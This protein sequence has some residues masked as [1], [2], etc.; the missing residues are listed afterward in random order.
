[1]KKIL[2]YSLAAFCVLAVGAVAHSSASLQK[3][4]ID[5]LKSYGWEVSEKPIEKSDFTLPEQLDSVYENYNELQLEAGLNLI[6]H[7]GK[8][9]VRYTYR[10]MNYPVSAEQEVRA[11]LLII[12]GKPIAGDIC[13][14]NLQGFM[15]S[16]KFPDK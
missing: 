10:V 4:N 9:G 16:L 1:M 12:D 14:V 5:F 15:H 13:T 2:F 11:N 3:N 7:L 8:S 6:P